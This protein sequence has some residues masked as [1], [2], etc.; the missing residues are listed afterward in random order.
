MHAVDPQFY[1]T[2]KQMTSEEIMYHIIV[3]LEGDDGTRSCRW[4]NISG[5]NPALYPQLDKFI[6]LA[7]TYGYSIA[8][9]TQGTQQPEWFSDIEL[10]TISPKPPSA[11]NM[12][13]VAQVTKCLDAAGGGKTQI[14]IPILGVDDMDYAEL[15]YH[16]FMKTSLIDDFSIQPVNEGVD[17]DTAFD[18]EATFNKMRTMVKMVHERQMAFCRVTPQL[19]ALLWG[20]ERGR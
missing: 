8:V 1:N 4:I 19:H 17:P 5:G 9:E 14:K 15:M 18:Q 7:K 3:N 20:N 16:A 12:T 13:T 2:W 10:L 11:G 6:A